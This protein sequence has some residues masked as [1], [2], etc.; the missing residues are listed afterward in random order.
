[1]TPCS[2]TNI[3]YNY[4]SKFTRSSNGFVIITCS[5]GKISYIIKHTMA[6]V[7]NRSMGYRDLGKVFCVSNISDWCR[8]IRKIRKSGSKIKIR[9]HY[10]GPNGQISLGPNFHVHKISHSWDVHGH[11]DTHIDGHKDTHT[12][13]QIFF[14]YNRYKKKDL[15][16]C[17]CVYFTRSQYWLILWTW[18]FGPRLI[19]PL[20]PS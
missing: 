5:N 14:L 9:P 2:Q 3:F 6:P 8:K 18:K 15:S 10:D 12:D 11:T 1:M 17:L 7:S 13:R 20:A 4:T 16:V 19:C